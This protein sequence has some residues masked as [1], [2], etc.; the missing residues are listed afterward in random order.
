MSQKPAVSLSNVGVA[1]GDY[2]VFSGVNMEIGEGRI[3]SVVG[4]NGSGKTTLARAIL[5]FVPVKEGRIEVFGELPSQIRRSG[6]ASYLPQGGSYDPMFPVSVYDVVAMGRLSGKGLSER[7]TD[8]DRAHID[9]S[10]RRL[11]ITSLAGK[12]FGSLSGGQRQRG[13]IARALVSRPKLLILDEPSTGLDAPAQS[14]FYSLLCKIRDELGITILII[15]HDL[16]M[17]SSFVDKML[18]LN[19]TIHYFLNPREGIAS[20]V[21]EKIFGRNMRLVVH[22]S[23]CLGCERG[24][25]D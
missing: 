8:E 2:R 10:L 5:G 9:E 20:G 3:V 12:H 15:S 22:D 7:L 4:P 23:H 11:D 16:G 25:H 18:L 14:D 1:Y 19:R 6:I 13:L 17:V 24:K 21:I